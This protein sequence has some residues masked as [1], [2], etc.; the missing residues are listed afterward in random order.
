MISGGSGRVIQSWKDYVEGTGP[1][2]LA[3]FF[4]AMI[5]MSYDVPIVTWSSNLNANGEVRVYA[6]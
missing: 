1:M 4:H 3:D 2:N 6:V 5:T